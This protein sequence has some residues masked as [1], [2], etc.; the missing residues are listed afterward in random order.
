[1]IFVDLCWLLLLGKKNE[2]AENIYVHALFNSILNTLPNYQLNCVSLFWIFLKITKMPI[3][4]T[5]FLKTKEFIVL[6]SFFKNLHENW[7]L[8]TN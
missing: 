7:K 3:W 5:F 8:P 1:M 6:F 4:L 2:F